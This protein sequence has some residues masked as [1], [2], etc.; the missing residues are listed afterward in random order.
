MPLKNF[1]AS[2]G[3]IRFLETAHS[4]AMTALVQGHCLDVKMSAAIIAVSAGYV[5]MSKVCQR[6]VRPFRARE[7]IDPALDFNRVYVGK[8]VNDY[9]MLNYVRNRKICVAVDLN[10]CISFCASHTT[11]AFLQRTTIFAP[12]RTS[13]CAFLS[14]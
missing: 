2:D 12:C 11:H 3:K 6:C 10:M 5:H 4:K 14:G 13:L 7:S 1:E 9:I 8:L